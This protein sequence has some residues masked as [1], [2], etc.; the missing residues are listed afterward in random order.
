MTRRRGTSYLAL[1]L[2]ILT[3]AAPLAA[4]VQPEETPLR[5]KSFRQEDLSIRARI[6]AAGEEQAQALAALGVAPAAAY[7]DG[8]TGRFA[9]LMPAQPL[10]P[11]R[12]VGNELTW[13]ELAVDP[14]AGD[15]ALGRQAWKAFVGYLEEHRGALGI[16]V[17]EL[18][19]PGDVTVHEGGGLVQIHA[20]RL[21]DGIP[22]R[23]AYLTAVIRHG[24]LVL[25]GARNWGDVTAARQPA[26][27]VD[28]ALA[29]V[30]SYL[31]DLPNRVS[32]KKSSLAFVPAAAGD[33]LAF[34]LAWVA[35]PVVEGDLG[36]WEALVDAASGELLAF[37]DLNHYATARVVQGGVLP[38]SNDGM[39][40]E[41]TEQ[42][43]WPM[44]FADLENGGETLFTDAG[45]SLLACVDGT[46]TTALSGRYM[47][48]SDQC[49]AISES[50]AGDVL[51]LGTSGG[52]DCTVP[53]GASPG[54]THASRSG[55]YEMNRIKEQ[56]R[57]Q[58]PANSWL[59]EQLTAN[60]NIPQFCN[61][62]WSG[63]T[64]N[65]YRS[66]GGCGNT[67]ELAGVYDHEWGHG[68][69]DNDANPSIS[70]PG[71]GIADIYAYLRL[72][73]SCI[74]RGFLQG[75]ACNGYG[76]PCVGSPPCDGVRDI[77]WANRAS[78]VP[79]DLD[80]IDPT[81]GTG[82]GTPCGGSSHCEGAVYAEAL[83]DLVNRDLP[84]LFGL[85]FNTAHEI[86]TRLSYLGGGAVGSWYTC[87]P[88][89]GGCNADGGYLHYLAADDDNG[90][91]SDG[92][93][94]MTAIFD[95]FDRHQIACATPTVQNGGCA[96]GPTTA[97]AVVATPLDRGASL[98]WGAVGGASSY[99]VFR[100]EGVFACDFGKT[101]VG[102]TT[103]TSFVDAGMKN[104]REY[105]YTVIPIGPDDACF[106]PA[107]SCTAVTPAPAGNLAVAPSPGSLT[108]VTGDGD[109]FL[110]N[111]EQLAVG[112]EVSNIG[113]GTQ[114][115]VRIVG[116]EGVDN[117]E[118]VV[119]TPLPAV[120]DASM[121]DCEVSEGLITIQAGG[122]SL[123]DPVA[124][125]VEVTSDELDP[126]VRS[127]I[128][129]LGLGTEGDFQHF[130]TKTFSYETD[131][132]N[133]QVVQGTFDRTS[134]GAG[135]G[136]GAPPTDTYVASSG[137][138]P[139]QCDHIRSPVL[140][141]AADSTM[142]LW[143]NFDIEPFCT[144]CSPP[145]WYDRA[146]VG[147][148]DIGAGSRTLVEPSSGRLYNASGEN[149]TCGTDGQP[150]WAGTMNTWSESGF[151]AGDLDAGA[152]AG[153]LIQLDVRYGTDPGLHL[154]GFWFDEVTLTN[155]D[156]QIEDT[157]S[158]VCLL[159]LIFADGFESGDVS[160][161]S[162]V[163]P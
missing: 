146:N 71:E 104:G 73:T 78:G 58:L 63:S 131:I 106:G 56:A 114:T 80:F 96:G 50:T 5:A 98:S 69:D 23:D 20:P 143:N 147:L 127:Q 160:A 133:W 108:F 13:A 15:A 158:D 14:P 70:S 66:G 68:M 156:L 103:G 7:V 77:D 24:N 140:S 153:D 39:G 101:L 132:E 122:L 157:Q 61:A 93:P 4:I 150:G 81:C 137:F 76:D 60:M 35:S 118:I 11:G 100:T 43:G 32:F 46:I 21:I 149:G 74:G 113:T 92:T 161:W 9:T 109:S 130:A 97:P 12:G 84:S 95:A 75:S 59:D 162:T 83:F 151:T 90:D 134:T 116:V 29:T 47:N 48:M 148:Y 145:S 123:N 102:E 88:P 91:L 51:D 28:Q 105:S 138:L 117:P 17:G 67:G 38:E 89:F 54:N 136:G 40:P 82:G 155:V 62:F 45:G 129:F 85:D 141:L 79:H 65:F 107:S 27:S 49:G 154:A 111:C 144:T 33:G 10:L 37:E 142:T 126:L 86:G 125:R 121:T 52:S 87:T 31:A 41:G 44:P 26:I 115:N 55:F 57:A 36:T 128:V 120:V 119:V 2:L 112:I 99:R 42:P 110:D 1:T 18:R 53:P 135:S 139:D 30:R 64:V 8:R 6:G 34:R 152:I 25:L 19:S 163:N 16:D 22:V 94:H 159:G 72:N 124:I 3:A